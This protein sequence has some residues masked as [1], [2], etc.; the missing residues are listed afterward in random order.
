MCG[1]AQIGEQMVT[2]IVRVLDDLGGWR[3]A[4]V[5][6]EQE[7]TV[8]L[9]PPH[10]AFIDTQL[11]A[12]HHTMVLPAGEGRSLNAAIISS[13]LRTVRSFRY[14]TNSGLTGSSRPRD[15]VVIP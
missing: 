3:D 2:A 8:H 5:G 12:Q 11:L 6:N 13:D 1:P 10:P 4:I 7:V 9:A 15:A 14:Q